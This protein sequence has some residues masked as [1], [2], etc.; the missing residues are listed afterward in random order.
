MIAKPRQLG[1][2]N[3]SLLFISIVPEKHGPLL[4]LNA[5]LIYDVLQKDFMKSSTQQRPHTLFK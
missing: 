5:S 4:A 2:F 3:L 1:Y